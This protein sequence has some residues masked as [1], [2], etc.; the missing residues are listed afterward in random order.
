MIARRAVAGYF[1]AIVLLTG[2]AFPGAAAE[3]AAAVRSELRELRARIDAMSK[4]LAQAEASKSG[5][6]DA[7]RD[8]ERAISE[9]QREMRELTHKSESTMRELAGLR[10]ESRTRASSLEAQ[11]ELLAR[12]LRHQHASGQAEALRLVLNQQ[13]PNR[14]ARQLHYFGYISRARSA[15]IGELRHNLARLDELARETSRRAAELDALAA[16]HVKHERRLD[17]ERQ[18]RARALAAITR[19]IRQQ[20][21]QIEVMRRNETRLGRLVEELGRII[22]RPRGTPRLRNERLP[23]AAHDGSPFEALKGRLALPVRGELGNRFGSPRSD[24]GPAWK[25]LFI[26]ARAGEEVRA[27]AAGRVVYAD[28]LRGFGNLLIIDHGGAYMSLYGYNEALYKQVGDRI[29][30]GDPIAVVGNSGGNPDS[31][32]YFEVRHEGRPLD[33]LTWVNVR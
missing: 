25:G 29:R 27:I 30:G 11:R 1:V 2:S 4:R 22:A 28:W 26:A 15:M 32:L 3:R 18:S 33:P 14:I 20:Q 24:G 23:D 16:E 7:L 17:Q 31:G 5:V 19:E 13:E 10:A 21:H 9:A 8:A 6:V 12:L